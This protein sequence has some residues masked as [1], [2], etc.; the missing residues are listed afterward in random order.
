MMIEHGPINFLL[1]TTNLQQFTTRM[2]KNTDDKISN[3][4]E[5]DEDNDDDDDDDDD[6]SDNDENVII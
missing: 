5:I 1:T 4:Y 2:Q 3:N 6:D